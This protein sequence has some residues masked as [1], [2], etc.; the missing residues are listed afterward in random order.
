MPTLV[1]MRHGKAEPHRSP[2][3]DR[4]LVASGRERTSAVAHAHGDDAPA[5]DL[6]VTSAAPRALQTAQTYAEAL[7][8][9]PDAVVSDRDLYDH[10]DP[11][12]LLGVVRRHAGGAERVAVFGHNPGLSWLAAWL[13]GDRTLGLRKSE[14][15]E[16]DCGESWNDVAPG[17]GVLVRHLGPKLPPLANGDRRP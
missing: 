16:I 11:E 17:S 3:F 15:V 8:L 13:T 2:D 1:I 6:L 4:E 5:P 7:G 12:Q 14:L 10:V 9:A